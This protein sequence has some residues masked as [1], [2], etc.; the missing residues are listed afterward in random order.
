MAKK[1]LIGASAVVLIVAGGGYWTYSFYKGKMEKDVSSVF[2]Y[3]SPSGKAA[4]KTLDYNIFSD[5]VTLN[6]VELSGSDVTMPTVSIDRIVIQKPMR[7]NVRKVFNPASYTEKERDRAMLPLAGSLV[8][9]GLK[10]QET[11][12]YEVSLGKVVIDQPRARPFEQVPPADLSFLSLDDP[13][14]L[15]EYAQALGFTSV[16][17]E[18]LLAEKKRQSTEEDGPLGD[19]FL[20]EDGAGRIQ[21]GKAVLGSTDGALLDDTVLTSFDLSNVSVEVDP[22]GLDEERNATGRSGKV[23]SRLGSLTLG[24]INLKA[25]QAFLNAADSDGPMAVVDAFE[26]LTIGKFQIDDYTFSF[27]ESR[28]PFAWEN[29]DDGDE[30]DAS[31]DVPKQENVLRHEKNDFALKNLS[32]T[33]LEKGR[34]GALRIEGVEMNAVVTPEQYAENNVS[35]HQGLI[36]IEN[37]NVGQAFRP[38]VAMLDSGSSFDP[39]WMMFDQLFSPVQAEKV[40]VRDIRFKETKAVGEIVLEELLGASTYKDDILVAS[41]GSFKGL[42]WTFPEKLSRWDSRHAFQEMGYKNI[43]LSG[44]ATESF[45]PEN[46]RYQMVF[47]M[48]GKDLGSMILKLDLG[49][50]PRKKSG[51]TDDSTDALPRALE[52][53]MEALFKSI[54]LHSAEFSYTDASLFERMIV[55]HASD[56]PLEEARQ[57]IADGL[58]EE[59][60]RMKRRMDGEGNL[61]RTE[62]VV[63]EIVRFINK[64]ATLTFVAKP[65]KP[66]LFGDAESYMGERTPEGLLNFLGVSA[67]Y[68]DKAKTP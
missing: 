48:Q 26:G 55:I 13:A 6:G 42:T 62:Q 68:T 16:T 10:G 25:F 45:N 50:Y 65:E 7:D 9:E 21:I 59:V 11:G 4:Y 32:V 1:L 29:D 2:A 64:P 12:P 35:Y 27:E 43:A 67:T 36:L 5:T 34:L 40:E 17:L 41:E 24:K 60:D 28:P 49:N 66:V 51:G 61:L 18:N 38:M 22:H 15:R 53:R 19:I 3:I 52:R 20:R 46:Q 54:E 23:T 56:M 30:D 8:L 63:A 39:L 33:S 37:I 58:M 47:D 14:T 44:K 31:T 57:E